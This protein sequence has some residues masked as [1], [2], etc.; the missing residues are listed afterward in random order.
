[1]TNLTLLEY[2]MQSGTYS[3]SG[4]TFTFDPNPN[5]IKKSVSVKWRIR[6][7]GYG[8]KVERARFRYNEKIEFTI[9][10]SCNANKRDELEWFSK[11]DSL[12]RI[13]NWPMPT[14][15]SEWTPDV[16]VATPPN[17]ASAPE[18]NVY[19][20]IESTDFTQ[21]EAKLDWFDYSLKVVRVH[22]TRR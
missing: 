2:H 22:P 6:R 18:E 10:G 3:P 16:P 12:F 15:H 9:T 1:M 21:T 7:P 5:N 11:R 8:N 14:Y 4:N 20:V 17:F 13:E 19:F